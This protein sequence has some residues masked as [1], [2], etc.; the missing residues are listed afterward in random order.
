M[1]KMVRISALALVAAFAAS[2]SARATTF[3]LESY[4][5]TLHNT[6]PGLV[7]W[8]SDILNAPTSFTLDAVGDV[9]SAALFT[10][11][12][13]E[14][15]LNLDDLAP[16]P[17]DVALAFSAPGT[18]GGVATGLTG[19][20]WFFGSFGYVG[21]D[22]PLVLA[23]G[24][25]GLLSVSLSNAKFG[26]PGYATIGVTFELLRADARSVPEPAALALLGV[27]ATL[28][29]LRIRRRRARRV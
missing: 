18:F 27:G 11:G 5:V 25:S 13:N 23:F 2:G 28:A 12:T 20:A 9:F 22:N 19:A 21:W 6:D 14:S 4:T 7:L 16:Y 10:L 29:A 1:M 3:E 8:S 17:I 26:L 15:A 24:E